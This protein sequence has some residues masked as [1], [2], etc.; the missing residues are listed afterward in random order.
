MD[1]PPR[2]ARLGGL[3]ELLERQGGGR[4]AEDVAR[5]GSPHR[6][7]MGG[8]AGRPAGRAGLSNAVLAP[9]LIRGSN[10]GPP[11]GRNSPGGRRSSARWPRPAGGPLPPSPRAI[12]LH[13]RRLRWSRL[14][15]A[16]SD[17]RGVAPFLGVLRADADRVVAVRHRRGDLDATHDRPTA[18]HD[19]PAGTAAGRTARVMLVSLSGD[20]GPARVGVVRTSSGPIPRP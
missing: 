1:R 11:L 4:V 2:R 19:D 14:Q 6:T 15:M 17:S 9:G 8:G 13:E 3:D 18:V 12:A 20:A 16:C 5:H 7:F 10:A